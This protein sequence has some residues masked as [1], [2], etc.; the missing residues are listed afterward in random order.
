MLKFETSHFLTGEELSQHE[1]LSLLESASD[2]KKNRFASKDL[3]LAGKSIAL[4]FEKPSLRTRVSFAVGIHELGG[5]ALDLVQA[6]TKAEDPEDAIRVLQGMVEGVMLRTFA[7]SNLERMLCFAKIPII[8][9]LSDLHHPC[10]ALAD[11]LTLRERFVRLQGLRLAYVGDGNNVLHSLLL[12]APFVGVDVHYSCP[13]GHQPQAEILTRAQTR[14]L[15]GRAKIQA[16]ATA[17]EAVAGCDAIYTDVWASMG[18]EAEAELRKK[19]F[20]DFQVNEA[21][22]GLASPQAIVMHCLP[23]VKGQEIT[24]AVVED[25]RSALFEQAANRLHVQKALL[26]GLFAATAIETKKGPLAVGSLKRKGTG[27]VDQTHHGRASKIAVA[28]KTS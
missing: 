7:H 22:L 4:I 9:G 26:A 3:P 16:F 8:N 23:M 17:Q 13:A 6:Q 20:S 11:L 27:H 18:K 21:L 10:Q 25:P 14:A 12:L 19:V 15:Q 28:A 24:A 5:H 2:M 1:L